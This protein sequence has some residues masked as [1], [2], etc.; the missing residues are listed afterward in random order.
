MDI[1]PGSLSSFIVRKKLFHILGE[2]LEVTNIRLFFFSL[3]LPV[4]NHSEVLP[5][6]RV[7]GTWVGFVGLP[8]AGALFH[9]SLKF[10]PGKNSS[11]NDTGHSHECSFITVFNFIH[12]DIQQHI[13][14]FSNYGSVFV[15]G[16]P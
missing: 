13:S 16:H 14:L 8:A 9:Y 1:L 11:F 6:I 2:G 10:K 4:C 12:P 3:D 5:L 7:Q 15:Y